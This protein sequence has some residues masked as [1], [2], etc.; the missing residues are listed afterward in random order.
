M[1]KSNFIIVRN[2]NKGTSCL[3]LSLVFVDFR[4]GSPEKISHLDGKE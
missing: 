3:L 4:R 2:E 1:D